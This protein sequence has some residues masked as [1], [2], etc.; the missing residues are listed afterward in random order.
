MMYEDEE[1]R[2]IIISPNF[3]R[4]NRLL[5]AYK[6]AKNYKF[7]KAKSNKVPKLPVQYNLI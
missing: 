1:N 3:E 5:A 4:S 7:S 2:G 6:I